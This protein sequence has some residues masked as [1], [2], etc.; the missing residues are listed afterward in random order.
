MDFKKEYISMNKY[1]INFLRP[2]HNFEKVAEMA[3]ADMARHTLKIKFFKEA[4]RDKSEKRNIKNAVISELKNRIL[5][6]NEV[7]TPDKFNTWHNKVCE[8]IV[9]MYN[10]Q[11][12]FASDFTY[13]QAQ[14]WLNMLIKYLYVFEV[15]DE[16]ISKTP[17]LE[18]VVGN[19]NPN[20][21]ISWLH[22]PIDGLVVKK[23]E[24]DISS[25]GAWS[26]WNYTKYIKYQELIN[27]KCKANRTNPFYWELEMWSK[28]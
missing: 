10:G 19:N 5:K 11:K 13:G 23:M 7:D 27:V 1:A 9:D 12:H 15:K 24:I 14:K 16:T 2:E 20:D 22:A 4:K 6:L 25:D 18:F 26:S 3:Y 8:Y 28:K 21:F 17:L